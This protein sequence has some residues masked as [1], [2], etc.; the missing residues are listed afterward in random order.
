MKS[1]NIDNPLR[2]DLSD[3]FRNNSFKSLKTS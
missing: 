3:Q 1:T 2:S